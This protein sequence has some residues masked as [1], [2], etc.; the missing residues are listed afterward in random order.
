MAPGLQAWAAS[1]NAN[2]GIDGHPVNLILKEDNNTPATGLAEAKELVND[3]VV[4][5][6][7]DG[8]FTDYA[9]SSIFQKAGIPIVG[10][11]S[12]AILPNNPLYFPSGTT[13]AALAY[14]LYYALKVAGVTKVA[15][16]YC[17]EIAACAT[18]VSTGKAASQAAGLQ[19]VWGG[20]VSASSP[21]LTPQCLAARSAGAN[22]VEVAVTEQ[23][24]IHL[25]QD[26][27]QQGWH[28][29]Y[30]LTTN[31]LND[32]L[33]SVPAFATETTTTSAQTTVP[34]FLDSTPALQAFHAAMA[35]YEPGTK[36]KS[37]AALTAWVGGMLFEAAAQASGS[38]TVTSKSII[39]GLYKLHGD[40]LGGLAPALTYTP[41]KQ[42]T[43]DCFFIASIKSGQ[44]SAPLG[45][46]PACAPPSVGNKSEE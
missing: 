15:V 1:V 36:I 10:G 16:P 23:E 40:T 27:A 8:S 39:N 22:G 25:A 30:V 7:F 38:S 46:N 3:H 17:A 21:D 11:S 4:A 2:G 41:G 26:C 45:L 18:A 29:V 6:V 24:S 20:G 35:K 32:D 9:W 19:V 14:G 31:G 13:T 28:P 34:W 44:Y 42:A 43:V 12:A 33:L 5:V 37:S